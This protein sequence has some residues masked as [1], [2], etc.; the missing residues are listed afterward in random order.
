MSSCLP[1]QEQVVREIKHFLKH[2]TWKIILLSGPWGAGKTFLINKHFSSNDGCIYISLYGAK[3]LDELRSRIAAAWVI[4]TANT[5]NKF[6][7]IKKFWMYCI[8][9]FPGVVSTEDIVHLTAKG[10]NQRYEQA[11]VVTFS[12]LLSSGKIDTIILDDL[13]RNNDIDFSEL[14]GFADFLTEKT[15]VRVIFVG[16]LDK[17]DSEDPSSVRIEIGLEKTVSH[18]ISLNPDLESMT[19]IAV[20]QSNFSS[21][22]KKSIRE[23][24]I[25]ADVT[26]IRLL[27][28]AVEH[29]DRFLGFVHKADLTAA[30][31]VNEVV[32][33]YLCLIFARFSDDFGLKWDEALIISE[34][35]QLHAFFTEEPEQS[36][37]AID[38]SQKINMPFLAFP[39]ILHK[40]V[41]SGLLDEEYAKD[42]FHELQA[43]PANQPSIKNSAT[44][45]KIWNLY[46]ESMAGNSSEISNLISEFLDSEVKLLDIRNFHQLSELAEAVGLKISEYEQLVHLSAVEKA[47]LRDLP[48][49]LEAYNGNQEVIEKVKSRLDAQLSERSLTD[50][51][52]SALNNRGWSEA[53]QYE[54]T[55]RTETQIR[56]WLLIPEEDKPAFVQQLLQMDKSGKIKR[57]LE[58][59]ATESDLNQMRA[60]RIY[61]IESKVEGKT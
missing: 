31:S 7:R 18:E 41:E 37:K 60:K 28:R 48:K 35:S 30:V 58:D 11:A 38:F 5:T 27:K 8:S 59:L 26:N 21:L 36:K 33:F 2:D 1:F 44:W 42:R 55:A 49:F 19:G 14:F 6:S 4:E 13:E 46:G 20:S 50:I 25:N 32:T 34:S 23:F 9:K 61:K 3:S 54:I 15:N 56:E 47:S 22:I 53:D 24:C 45:E 17:V 52:E 40:H 51:A 39:E 43:S 16:N 10:L 29:I 12:V 57:V